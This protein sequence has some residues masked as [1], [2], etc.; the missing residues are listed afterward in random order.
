M[1]QMD[2]HIYVCEEGC[3]HAP[4]VEIMHGSM[5]VYIIM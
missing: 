4:H 3:R 5:K 2:A 1:L